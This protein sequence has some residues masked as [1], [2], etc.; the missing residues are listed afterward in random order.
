MISLIIIERWKNCCIKP[1]IPDF[2]S[3]NAV[4]WD[5]FDIKLRRIDGDFFQEEALTDQASFN[6]IAADDERIK[7]KN[8]IQI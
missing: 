8:V 2:I 3:D 5:R 1:A 6:P 4:I 7:I